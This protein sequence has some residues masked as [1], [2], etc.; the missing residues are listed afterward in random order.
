MRLWRTRYVYRGQE[1]YIGQISRDIGV[2]FNRRTFTTHVIDPDVDDTR[3]G[4]IGDLA[5]SQSLHAMGYVRGS[6]RST[7]EETHYN[8][9]PDPYFSDGLRAVMFLDPRPVALNEIQILD[10]ES[11]LPQELL[12]S[13]TPPPPQ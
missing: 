6:Q 7:R 5:Y 3:D 2:K 1:V 4:L 12:R 9:T 11:R 8:L 13:G 10:W